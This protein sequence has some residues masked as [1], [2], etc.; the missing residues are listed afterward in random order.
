MRPAAS[1]IVL[2]SLPTYRQWL[3]PIEMMWRHFRRE[4]THCELFKTMPALLTAA[5]ECFDRFNQRPQQI[6]SVIGSNAAKA[7]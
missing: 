7:T 1:R 3:N 6:L 4:V 2:L 5:R